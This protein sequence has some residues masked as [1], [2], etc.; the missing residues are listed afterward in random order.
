MASTPSNIIIIGLT[1]GIASGKSLVRSI[2]EK[3]DTNVVTIDADVLGHK[4][5]QQGSETI[6]HLVK[7]F[8]T[9]ILTPDGLNIHRPALGALVFNN[10]QA[11]N[12]LSSIVWPAIR[13][14]FLQELEQIK[15]NSIVILE[16]AIL[17][18]AG[19]TDLVDEIWCTLVTPSMAIERIMKRNGI[20]S[21]DAE[22]RINSQL[23]NQERQQ[24]SHVSIW[25]N[26]NSMEQLISTIHSHWNQFKSRHQQPYRMEKV[27]IVDEHTNEIIDIRKRS[28]MRGFNLPHRATYVIC[29]LK[30]HT[31]PFENRLVYVQKRAFIKDYFP[32]A[33]DPAPGGVVS[34]EDL[35]DDVIGKKPYEL[36]AHREMQEEMGLTRLQLQFIKDFYISTD[37]IKCWGRIFMCEIDIPLNQLK[38]QVEEV[39]SVE[40]WPVKDVLLREKDITPDGYRAFK[41]FVEYMKWKLLGLVSLL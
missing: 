27:L 22:K 1:G 3:L 5:Y 9:G 21:E 25:N 37:K 30:N 20:S 13:E 17:L 14:L 36:N 28:V 15:P 40:L 31:I 19:W 7:R 10:K 34:A 24:K 26:E 33:Y 23:S 32:G 38:L 2:V 39:H 18:E 16:A 11:L 41:E 6:H 8:G 12:D 4:A 29:L 35:F